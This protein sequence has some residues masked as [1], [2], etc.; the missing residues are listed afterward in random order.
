[1]VVQGSEG[2]QE[3]SP[4]GNSR[5]RVAVL[6]TALSLLA[7]SAV[8]GSK[9]HLASYKDE[10]FA[11][12]KP[13]QTLYGGSFRVVEYSIQRDLRDRDEVPEKKAKADY[14]SLDTKKAEQVLTITDGP[15]KMPVAVVG[16]VEGP[17]T[18][19]VMFL[20]GRGAGLKAGFD[21]WN[22][23]GNFNRI[24]NLMLRS[25]GLYVSPSFNSFDETGR[26]QI[27]GLMRALAKGSPDAPVF[28]ACA[29]AAGRLCTAL[30]ADKEAGPRLGGIIFLGAN[31]K[32]IEPAAAQL[33]KTGY[34]IPVFIGHGSKDPVIDWVRQELFFTAVRE[35][36]PDYPIRFTLY[37]PG[38]HGT[39][40]R[41]VDWRE[42]INWMLDV[43]GPASH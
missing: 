30:A 19:I 26:A 42:V 31:V 7:L 4:A 40:M 35:A 28:L 37:K 27:K 16:K 2:N 21:D 18:V 17:A 29:S 36:T 13:L 20:H 15:N 12:P 23:G 33:T 5:L 10:L 39:P 3:V 43:G 1:L 41:M 6:A 8:A 34:R 22:F 11:N 14:V 32:E 24:K 9:F 25:G 38:F